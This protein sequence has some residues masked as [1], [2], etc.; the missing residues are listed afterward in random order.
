MPKDSDC[1]RYCSFQVIWTALAR[2][3]ENACS[4]CPCFF[5]EPGER[6]SLAG[7]MVSRM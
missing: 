3:A 6:D 4:L 1:R 2:A 7:R 5:Y